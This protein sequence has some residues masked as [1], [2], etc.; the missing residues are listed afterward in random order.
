MN[1]G[2]RFESWWCASATNINNT[3]VYRIPDKIYIDNRSKMIRS[4]QSEADYFWFGNDW[5]MIVECKACGAKSM[6]FAALKEHQEKMLL[7]F[8][9]Y[10]NAIVAVNLYDQNDL[11]NFNKLFHVPIKTW[12]FLKNDLGRKSIPLQV[13]QDEESII[14]FER[15]KGSMWDLQKAVP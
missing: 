6:P 8:S 14:E 10:M 7:K 2:K 13:L 1:S 5:A 9:E 3:I 12:V 15:I 11:R 4:S